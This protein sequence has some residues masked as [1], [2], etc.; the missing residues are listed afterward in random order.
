MIQYQ[1]VY[2]AFMRC[3]TDKL[4]EEFTALYDESKKDAEKR[5]ETAQKVIRASYERMKNT[6][7][8]SNDD[9]SMIVVCKSFD[10]AGDDVACVKAQEIRDWKEKHE[11]NYEPISDEALTFMSTDEIYNAIIFIVGDVHGNYKSLTSSLEKSG[12]DVNADTIIFVGDVV[13]RGKENA[14]VV[15]FIAEHKGNIHLICG[16]HEYQHRQLLK[17]YRALAKAPAI[18]KMAAGIFRNYAPE[19]RVIRDKSEIERLRCDEEERSKEIE[20]HPKTF[21]EW[22][23]QF[24]IYTLAWEDDSL[25]QIVLYLLDEMCGPPYDAQHTIYEYLSG[26]NQTRTNFE[27]VFENQT[28][29]LNIKPGPGV[30][31]YEQVVVSHNNPFGGPY[32]YD[33]Q[34]MLTGHRNIL[35]IFGHVSHETMTRNDRKESGCTFLDIDTSPKSVTVIALDDYL[36][37]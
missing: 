7:L 17:Y 8:A 4:A 2:D 23:K 31:R 30:H 16:N 6:T 13:D 22:Q 9:E 20:K 33:S 24:L 11:K 19:G 21:V 35:Y 26:T 25:W 14:K 5:L 1:N 32:S 18:R 3:D 12:C 15:N 34:E 10:D 28:Q 27:Q 29:E 36:K 37:N